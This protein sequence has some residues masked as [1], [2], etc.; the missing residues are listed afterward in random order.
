MR[1]VNSKTLIANTF[2]R[3]DDMFLIAL[4]D[5]GY[6]KLKKLLGATDILELNDTEEKMD[7]KKK[8]PVK[9]V[10]KDVKPANSKDK[11]KR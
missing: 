11:K 3:R 1:K 8:Q 9:E 2:N 7:Q 5:E 4:N 6:L 10:K